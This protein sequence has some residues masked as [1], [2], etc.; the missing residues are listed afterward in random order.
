MGDILFKDPCT[1][2]MILVLM[3]KVGLIGGLGIM[4]LMRSEIKMLHILE[5]LLSMI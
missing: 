3:R 5:A 2:I 1:D 4:G